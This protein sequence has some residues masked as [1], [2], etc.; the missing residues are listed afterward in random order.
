MVGMY[1]SSTSF[2]LLVLSFFSIQLSFLAL[3]SLSSPYLVIPISPHH[4]D[5]LVLW[6]LKKILPWYLTAWSKTWSG[7]KY[8]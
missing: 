3:S 5:S 1:V 7:L 4:C 2:L 6:S 8:A